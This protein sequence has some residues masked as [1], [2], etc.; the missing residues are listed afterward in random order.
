[1]HIGGDVSPTRTALLNLRID[2]GLKEALRI[3]AV[4]EHRSISNMVEW[5]VRRHCE[6][7]GISIPEQASL[8]LEDD[9]RNES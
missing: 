7:A 2:P 8:S 1:M 9:G 5:L 4:R 6:Q 3:A